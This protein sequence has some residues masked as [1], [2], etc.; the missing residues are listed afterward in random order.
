MAMRRGVMYERS[1]SKPSFV[2]RSFF[3][4]TSRLIACA[5]GRLLMWQPPIPGRCASREFRPLG[6]EAAPLEEAAR[7]PP[8]PSITAER[9]GGPAA[10]SNSGRSLGDQCGEQV[11]RKKCVT[12]SGVTRA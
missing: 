9:A 2:K 10:H 11:R 1:R 5:P 6:F 12:T 8:L 3:F 7:P 4:E